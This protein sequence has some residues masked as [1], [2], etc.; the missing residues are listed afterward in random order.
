MEYE[1]KDKMWFCVYDSEFGERW[2]GEGYNS[3]EA[4]KNMKDISAESDAV[5]AK[6]TF[7]SAERR[8]P[9]ITVKWPEE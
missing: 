9:L 6:C 1:L 5:L 3:K 2:I 8:N 7:Y 4:F